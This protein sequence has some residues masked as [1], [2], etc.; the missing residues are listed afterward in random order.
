MTPEDER[1]NYRVELRGDL[2]AFMHLGDQPAET[3][4]GQQ[5]ARAVSGA[6]V[7]CSRIMGSSVAG[8]GFEP[9]TFRL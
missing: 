7:F 6:G 4:A 1:G 9:V 3:E 5:N 2:A 8:T